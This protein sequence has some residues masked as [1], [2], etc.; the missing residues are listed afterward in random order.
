MD[1]SK[2]EEIEKAVSDYLQKTNKKIDVLINN[3]G[4]SMRADSINH[5]LEQDLYLLKVNLISYIA[6]TKVVLKNMIT[7][8]GGHI[9]AFSSI[10]GK[11]GIKNRTTYAASKHAV[12]GYFDSLRA[13]V[14]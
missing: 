9:V 12:I 8:K 11:L 3:A 1:L 7:N 2:T 6:F 5:S 13:E 4:L 10:Q 14:F